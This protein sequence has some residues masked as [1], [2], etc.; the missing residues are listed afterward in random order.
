MHKTYPGVSSFICRIE[1]LLI[2]VD[3]DK[4]LLH[5]SRETVILKLELRNVQALELV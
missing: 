5:V 1:E 2:K 4:F 3:A